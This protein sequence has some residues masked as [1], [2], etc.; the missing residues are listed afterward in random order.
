MSTKL[1]KE[2]ENQT[3]F[4]IGRIVELRGSAKHKQFGW[5][6]DWDY[7]LD[8]FQEE[9]AVIIG[10]DPAG[11]GI[12]IK[13]LGED[14]LTNEY[15]VPFFVLHDTGRQARVISLPHVD[16]IVTK[17]IIHVGSYDIP[18]NRLDDILE[19]VNKVSSGK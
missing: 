2:L 8:D 18:M 14:S 16:V 19:A 3:N 15:Y 11:K 10:F 9:E 5:A 13:F 1:Y 17:E 6:N 4:S 7:D 12:C